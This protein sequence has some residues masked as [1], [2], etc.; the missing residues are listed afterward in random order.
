MKKLV[1]LLVTLA[2]LALSGLASANP[3]T[4]HNGEYDLSKVQTIN[5]VE[6][7][8]KNVSL[9][10]Y[11]AET[12]TEA[13]V[14]SA[15]YEAADKHDLLVTEV[16]AVP[17]KASLVQGKRRPTVVNVKI[18][19]DKLGH[20]TQI[21]PAHYESRTK[22][23]ATDVYDKKG[24]KTGEARVPMVV[25]EYVPESA[26]HTSYLE[27]IYNVYDADGTLIFNSRDVRDREGT[28]DPFGMLERASKDFIKHMLKNK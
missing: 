21:E 18:T 12:D 14:K 15:L 25:Q 5:I 10:K 16:A 8:N 7:A 13:A 9:G 24:N 17:G 4:W 28:A 23:I 2:L 27:I 1:L 22:Y 3:T 11:V 20:E 19:V 6:I 26:Y